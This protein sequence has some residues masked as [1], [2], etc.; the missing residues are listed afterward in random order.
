[1]L[2]R[3]SQVELITKYKSKKTNKM[4]S[5]RMKMRKKISSKRMKMR[6]KIS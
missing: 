3:K 4:L 1:M 2:G 6:K 5:K